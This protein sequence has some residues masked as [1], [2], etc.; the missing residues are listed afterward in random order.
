MAKEFPNLVSKVY[1][2]WNGYCDELLGLCADGSNRKKQVICVARIDP[3]K[4]HSDLIKAF[5]RVIKKFNDW[6]LIIVGPIQ[7]RPYY[8]YLQVLIKELDLEEYVTFLG[9]IND[10]ELAR[11][12]SESSIFVLPS[13]LEGFS[14]A[15]VEALACGLPVITTATGGSEIIK[16]VGFVV[17]PG[18]INGLASALEK[19]MSNDALRA[20]LGEYAIK[21]ARELT[22]KK[23]AKK[24]AALLESL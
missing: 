22:W 7:D 15:R 3:V 8:N 23:V 9:M 2:V 19:L 18:D 20:K 4:G 1:V 12:Y 13:Y 10:Q 17:S 14:I 5:S 16:G 24:I 21:R 6:R 11:I